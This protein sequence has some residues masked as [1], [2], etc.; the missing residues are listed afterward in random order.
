MS[1]IPRAQP[2]ASAASVA[3]PVPTTSCICCWMTISKAFVLEPLFVGSASATCLK[4]PGFARSFQPE[5]SVVMPR[6]RSESVL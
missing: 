6:R 3:S 4:K 2:S 1:R 5:G